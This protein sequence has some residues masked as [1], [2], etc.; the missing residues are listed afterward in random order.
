MYVYMYTTQVPSGSA[1]VPG[2]LL[3]IVCMYACIH[4]HTHTHTHIYMGRDAP[5][6]TCGGYGVARF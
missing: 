3:Y 4:T 1:L 6:L 5:M 2:A